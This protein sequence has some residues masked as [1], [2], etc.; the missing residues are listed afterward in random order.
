MTRYYVAIVL[1]LIISRDALARSPPVED[2]HPPVSLWHRDTL[3]GDWGGL[4]TALAEQGITFTASYIGE[5]FANVQ[6]GM[7]RGTTYDGL[8]LPQ[9]DIDL[10]KLVG[11]QGATFRVSMLQAHGQSIATRY[12]GNLIGISNIAVV[13]PSTR[14]YNFWLQQNLFH[15]ALSI[16][17][18]LIT[19]DQD[20]FNSTVA[21]VFMNPGWLGLGL[22]GGGPAYPLPTPGVRVRVNPPEIA[23]GYLQAAVFSGDP[24][25]NNGS[26]SPTI[27]IPSGTVISFS[28]GAFFIAESGYTLSR[29]KDDTRLPT[30]VKVG[31]WYHTSR[32]FEDQRFATNGL[33]LADPASTGSPYEHSGNWALY[34]SVEGS[35]YRS[36]SGGEL[37][38]FARVGGSP[39]D[40]NVIPFYAEAGVAYKGLIPGREN[41]S[42]GLSIDYARISNRARGLDQ[43]TR[44]FTGNPL[45]PIRNYEMVLELTY[46]MQVTPWLTVQPDAQYVFNPG[47]HV[48]NDN[49]T[50]RPNALVFGLRSAI[51]F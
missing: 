30:A 42:T 22:P 3:T 47:G 11:W 4:R 44:F 20:F 49:G 35:L 33:S 5:V 50:V 43:D 45:F 40:R 13:P 14:L 19:V 12:V 7:K 17:A 6:G 16:R 41:D 18:G 28:G 23:G 38:G 48:L 25:G 27:G 36:G 15:D 46:Q 51:T 29:D 2:L 10:E 24:T 34:A 26:T 8:F 37:T 21:T 39:D 31:A 1:A 32:H 9:I